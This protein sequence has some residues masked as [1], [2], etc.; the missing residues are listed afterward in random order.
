MGSMPVLHLEN[1]RPSCRK[2]SSG[3]TDW[4]TIAFRHLRFHSTWIFSMLGTSAESPS[5]VGLAG[6]SRWPIWTQEQL[7]PG[8]RCPFLNNP[9]DASLVIL[10]TTS[11]VTETKMSTLFFLWFFGDGCIFTELG[12][13]HRLSPSSLFSTW[14]FVLERT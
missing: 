3:L 13:L 7:E 11:L 1:R 12:V 4:C 8:L 9:V 5:R 2:L 6:R 14:V 10:R